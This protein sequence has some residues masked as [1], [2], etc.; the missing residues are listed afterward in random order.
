MVLV[1]TSVWLRWFA[2]IRP[3]ADD[4]DRLLESDEIAGHNL[5]LGELL[6]GDRGGR[7]KFLETYGELNQ[8]PVVAHDEV[9]EFVQ[10]RKLHGIG[11][12]WIDAHL[13]ASA[14]ISHSKLWTA[15]EP[16]GAAAKKLSL[17]YL[18]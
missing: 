15:D 9:I 14:L 12:S 1:D 7:R 17:A 16:L 11:L 5:V 6:I 2:D 3:L 4:L 8:A 10:A 13:L 18:P